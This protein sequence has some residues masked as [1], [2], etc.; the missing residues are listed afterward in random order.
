MLS[1]NK[2]F[3][4]FSELFDERNMIYENNFIFEFYLKM[5]KLTYK[6]K[7]IFIKIKSKFHTSLHW[8]S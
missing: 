1:N 7:A 5:G 3:N 8:K 6:N 2:T 4:S